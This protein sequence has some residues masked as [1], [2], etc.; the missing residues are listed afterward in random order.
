MVHKAPD[1]FAAIVDQRITKHRADEAAREAQRQAAEAQRIAEAEERARAQAQAEAAEI[2]RQA[3]AK[4][5][6]DA[7]ASAEVVLEKLPEAVRAGV[8]E[9]QRAERI[10][11]LV[12]SLQAD[13]VIQG[14]RVAANEPASVKL[15]D[16]A[17]RLGFP[18]RADFIETTLGIKPAGRAGAAVLFQPRQVPAIIAALRQHLE[19]V[20]A[21]I[22]RA[23]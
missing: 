4:A 15:G 19:R 10:G 16:L 12:A 8:I 2:R 11:G 21:S 20:A 3:D 13:A 6:R 14:A 7:Q 17:D 22:S 18:L 5:A 1:D 23:A 9:P